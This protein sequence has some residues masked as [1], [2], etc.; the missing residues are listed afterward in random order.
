MILVPTQSPQT[1]PTTEPFATGSDDRPSP[2]PSPWAKAALDRGVAAILFLVAA[3]FIA[4]AALAVKLTSRGPA[5]YSQTRVG[6]N[7]RVFRI[8]KIR[9]MYHNCEAVSG[10]RWATKGDPRVTPVGR[11][12]RCTHLDE[13]PQLWN[14]LC[15]DMSLVGPR[16]ER[17]EF[18]AQLVREVPGYAE[19]LRV[20]PGV[21]GLAQVQLPADTDVESVRLKLQYDLH[22]IEHHTAWLDLRLMVSTAFKMLH[23]PFGVSKWLLRIPSRDGVEARGVAPGAAHGR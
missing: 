14:V 7:G 15:G 8:Y 23:L 1:P 3:P 17:P 5:F 4:V 18:V 10:A 6:L 20:R 22:Y 11:F 2:L 12:L 9:T 16:P 19:R 21:T 13:L